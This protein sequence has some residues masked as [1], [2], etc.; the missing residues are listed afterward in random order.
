MAAMDKKGIAHQRTEQRRSVS[1]GCS[2]GGKNDIRGSG[3]GNRFTDHDEQLLRE[4]GERGGGWV[5]VQC[6][7]RNFRVGGWVGV[8][9]I[10]IRKFDTA[11]ECPYAAPIRPSILLTL[12]A[13]GRSGRS[14]FHCSPSQR[15]DTATA[16]KREQPSFRLEPLSLCCVC[17][18]V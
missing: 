7:F 2:G 17:V 8:V 5:G 1:G 3:N 14:W 9:F 18:S 16:P 4:V 10:L 13:D 6:N 11:T 12:S 15:R